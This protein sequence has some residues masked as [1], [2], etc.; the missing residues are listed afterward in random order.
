ME[1]AKSINIDIDGINNSTQSGKE[2]LGLLRKKQT[3]IVKILEK[4]LKLVSINH[5]RKMWLALG[6]SSSI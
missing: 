6:M 2:M 4:E 5:Y 1:I 3:K